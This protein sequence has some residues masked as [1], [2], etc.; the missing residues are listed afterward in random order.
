[1]GQAKRICRPGP[2]LQI[3]HLPRGTQLKELGFM[4]PAQEPRAILVMGT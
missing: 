4:T 1:M 2:E 3:E